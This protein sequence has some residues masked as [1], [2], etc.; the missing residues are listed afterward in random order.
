MPRIMFTPEIFLDADSYPEVVP[1]KGQLPTLAYPFKLRDIYPTID[2]LNPID[3]YERMTAQFQRANDLLCHQL[4][5]KDNFILPIVKTNEDAIK[6]LGL[7]FDPTIHFSKGLIKNILSAKQHTLP[8]I[9]NLTDVSPFPLKLASKKKLLHTL[10]WID[11]NI[12]VSVEQVA[13]YYKI[14]DEIVVELVE[15]AFVVYCLLIKQQDYLLAHTINFN[16]SM[17]IQDRILALFLGYKIYL[18]ND[19]VQTRNKISN[20]IAL[21]LLK[22]LKNLSLRQ[23]CLASIFMGVVWVNDLSLQDSFF[24][25]S[26]SVLGDISNQLF[27]RNKKLAVDH[28]DA[29]LQEISLPN[30]RVV[31]VLDDNGESVF[32]LGLFQQIIMEYYELKIVFL[33]NRFP[34]SNNISEETFIQLIQ[35]PFFSD[36]AKYLETGPGKILYEEQFFRSFEKKYLKPN[37]YQQLQIPSIAY[38]KGANFFE[39]FHLPELVSYHIFTI[40]GEMSETLTGY[41]QG[42]GIFVR[43]PKKHLPF[44]YHDGEDIIT[45]RNQVE[46]WGG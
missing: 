44:I 45:L 17:F 12:K 24:L 46:S 7:L 19:V 10:A 29:F 43:I 14:P 16:H 33:V 38:I 8:K 31:V 37:T 2:N 30:T 42:Q 9:F 35:D 23:L 40:H 32:D 11:T 3:A 41:S 1:V 4:H 27:S 15:R 34:V 28:I 36:L 20:Q 39:T 13:K 26:D 6:V 5:L 18:Q 22:G 25:H 21:E